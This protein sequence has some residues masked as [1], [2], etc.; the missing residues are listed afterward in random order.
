M[1]HTEGWHFI[2]CFTCRNDEGGDN[3][4]ES[5]GGKLIAASSCHLVAKGGHLSHIGQ[6]LSM[7]INELV[8]CQRKQI[9][10]S[11]RQV[12]YIILPSFPPPRP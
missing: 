6:V 7:N 2:A 10:I 4:Q 3:L 1:V 12:S 8:N 9:R 5:Q 11:S